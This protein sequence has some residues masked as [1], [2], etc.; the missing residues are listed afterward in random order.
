MRFQLFLLDCHQAVSQLTNND[1]QTEPFVFDYIEVLPSV[2]LASC[3]LSWPVL[4]KYILCRLHYPQ[5]FEV[6]RA[7]YAL[8]SHN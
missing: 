6:A 7:S 1:G 4:N 5:P 3:R 2:S 8:S